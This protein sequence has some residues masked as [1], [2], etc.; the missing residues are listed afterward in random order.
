VKNDPIGYPESESD[1]NVRFP[2]LLGIQLHQKDSYSLRLRLRRR[3]P[4]LEG[5][6]VTTVPGASRSFDRV[7]VLGVNCP[8]WQ[9][10]LSEWQL[11]R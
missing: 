4:G 8:K 6:A 1:K 9:G 7:L 2:V 5:L 3:N 11:S 10:H